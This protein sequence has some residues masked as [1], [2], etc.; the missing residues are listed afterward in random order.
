MLLLE[1]QYSRKDTCPSVTL[2]CIWL[3][4]HNRAEAEDPPSRG[5][6]RIFKQTRRRCRRE[7]CRTV[8]LRLGGTARETL[9]G[10]QL[11]LTRGVVASMAYE[12]AM[13]Q[14]RSNLVLIVG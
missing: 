13:L 10:I 1:R 3:V 6:L 8:D 5:G 9:K 2:G 12:T 11:Q 14:K 4:G 7:S